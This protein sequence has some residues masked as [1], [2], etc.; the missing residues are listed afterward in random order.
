MTRGILNGVRVLDLSRMLSGPYCTMML[1]DHG[2]EV[3]KIES[4]GGDTSRANG[5]FRADDPDHLWAGYFVSLNRSKRSVKL[6]LKTGDGK[7]DF[8]TLV[9]SADVLVENFRPGVM[10]RLGLSYETLSEEN[11]RLVYAAIRGF[12]DPR[13]GESPYA[14]WPSYDVVAQAM[15]GLIGL[16]GPDQDTPTKVGPGIGDVFAGL[17]MSF[18]IMAGLRQAEATGKGQFIDVGMYDA[19]LS[20][21]ERAVY[22]YD[23]D[24]TVPGPQGNNHPLLAPFGIFPASDGHVA[25]GIVDDPFW[26][27]LTEVAG[28]PQLASDPRYA[29]RGARRERQDEVNAMVTDWTRHLSKAELTGLLGGKVPFGPLNTIADIMADPHVAR[30]KLIADIPHPEPGKR[31][32]KVAANPLRFSANPTPVPG[33]PARLGAD[34]SLIQEAL[35]APIGATHKKALRDAFG[36]FATGVAVITTRESDGTPRGF[37]ANAF[38]SVSLDPPLL[39]IC[40][41]KSAHSCEVFSDA[42]H[43]AVNILSDA[44]KDISN[45]FATQRPDKFDVAGWHSGAPDMPPV[46]DGTLASFTC[47]R[48]QLVDAGDH[49]ILIGRVVEFE[50]S[51]GAPLGYFRG[52]YFSIGLEDSL[53]EAAGAGEQ[54]MLS[55]VL[56]QDKQILLTTDQNGQCGLPAAPAGDTSRDGLCKALSSAGLHASLDFLYAVFRDKITGTHGIVYHG[57]ASGSPPKGMAY[58]PVG[59]LPVDR[60][61]DLSQRQ[62]LER[63]EKESRLGRFGVYEGDQISGQVRYVVSLP[64]NHAPLVGTNI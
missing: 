28:W 59:D 29:T 30:R 26:V 4:A 6:D 21:C 2:A 32:W 31:G 22:Q 27:T 34:Q 24:G 3:I 10:E 52:N 15:G 51:E 39:L 23:F 53:V 56:E 14:E 50:R 8:L 49:L 5:P 57:T 37:T 12:G 54:I 42:A 38:S 1:A 47:A 17:M 60:V 58:F 9:R 35:R 44:Q 41:A 46:L 13:S 63:Y 55:A 18:G 16:T 43:F 7:G 61:A 45:L 20:L 19:V 62:L 48:H 25:I 64:G 40:I 11:P 36:A 33:P